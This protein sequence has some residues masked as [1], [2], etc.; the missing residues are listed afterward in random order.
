MP[1]L[2]DDASRGV[3]STRQERRAKSRADGRQPSRM[4]EQQDFAYLQLAE[5]R[6]LREEEDVEE[7]EEEEEE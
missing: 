3:D 7:V 5:L 2:K 6:V 1:S 4:R